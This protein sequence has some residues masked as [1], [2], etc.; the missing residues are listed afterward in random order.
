[1][2]AQNKPM[3]PNIT[4]EVNNDKLENLLV[5]YTSEKSAESLNALISHMHNCRVLV[6]ANLNDKKQPMPCF[7]KNNDDKIFLPIYTSQKQLP[8]KPMSSGM[9]NIPYPAANQIAANPELKVEGIVINPF[10][11]NLVFKKELIQKIDEL[12]KNEAKL[13]QMKPVTLTEAQYM[14]L[15]R[16]TFELKFLP[17]KLFDMGKEFLDE[18][19]NRREEY[20]DELFEESYKEKRMY[21]Y[22]AEEFSVM[23]INVTENICIVRVDMPNRDLQDGICRRI[24]FV[25]DKELEKG[26][27]FTIE[28]AGKGNILAEVTC[29]WTHA[30]M[31]EAP[32]EGAELQRILDIIADEKKHT[33]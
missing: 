22:L 3:D 6:P 16:Q 29:D 27:Y 1:M 28:C 18:L 4:M 12:D 21:P 17:K 15:E 20:I 11:N 9:M 8:Q 19:S 10:S 14:V 33:S 32:V 13:K 7:I 24:F 23:T 26:R 31:G 2:C 5:R 25:W 30:G